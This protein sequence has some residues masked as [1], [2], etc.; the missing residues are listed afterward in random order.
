MFLNCIFL[1]QYNISM[2]IS[3]LYLFHFRTILK[4]A[5]SCSSCFKPIFIIL[6]FS[7]PCLG[8]F[9]FLSI[10][11][12]VLFLFWFFNCNTGNLFL[13]L[14]DIWMCVVSFPLHYLHYVVKIRI[15]KISYIS[16]RL[17]KHVKCVQNCA[18]VKLPKSWL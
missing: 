12:I 6:I 14:D 17:L 11:V 3:I 16:K 8:C 10:S 2:S 1:F 5:I 7:P 13:L 4:V 18:W 9:V 15:I